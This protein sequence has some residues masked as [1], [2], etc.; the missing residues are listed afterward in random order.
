MSRKYWVYK[1]SRIL[2]PFDKDAFAGLPGVD[3]TTLVSAGD[4]A[5]SGEGGWLP[6]GEIAELTG[7]ALDIG[8][9]W[10]HDELSVTYGLLDKLQIEAAGLIDDDDFPGAA[11]D[12]FQDA[13]QKKNFADLL[14]PR[15]A[16]AEAE[17]RRSKDRVSELTVQLEMLYKR[18]SE[19]ESS[20]TD[21]MHRLAE[22]EVALRLPPPMPVAA[23]PAAAPPAV[24]PPAAAPP[25][26]VAPVAAAPAAAPPAAVSPSLP[27]TPTPIQEPPVAEAPP[28]PEMPALA[29]A[30]APALELIP[31]PALPPLPE[32]TPPPAAVPPKKTSYPKPLHFK[33]VPTIR[34]FRIVSED[35]L[36]EPKPSAAEDAAPA[37]V[38]AKLPTLAPIVVPLPEPVLPQS[39]VPVPVPAPVEAPV[40]PPEIEVV[41]PPSV[42]VP[43]PVGAPAFAPVIEV[44]SM[45]R[46]QEPAPAA[47][48][49]AE[50]AAGAAFEDLARAPGEITAPVPAPPPVQEPAAAPPVTMSFAWGGEP[51][52]SSA[53]PPSTQEVLARLSKPGPAPQTTKPR[54]VRSNKPALFAG[55]ALVALLAVIG[56]FLLRQ[57][58]DLKQM[59]SLDDN[60]EHLGA[61]PVDEA[62]RIPLPKPE[63]AE[64]PAPDVPAQ[65]VPAGP[66]AEASGSQ[67]AAQA[68]LDAAVALA[69]DFP[70]DGGR[71]TVAQWLQYSYNASPDAGS[72]TWSASSTGDKGYLVEYRFVPTARGGADVHYLFAADMSLGL[73]Y[74]K[75]LEAQRMLAG[76]APR[77]TDQKPK[78]RAK[79]KAKTSRPAAKRPARRAAAAEIPREVPLMPLPDEGELKPPA[80]DDSAFGADTVNSGL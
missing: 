13:D 26:A 24:A 76:S 36:G 42:P 63:V 29:A 68:E 52:A 21:L 41:A 39:S 51:E 12:L 80:E 40:S 32:P 65:P 67:P 27:P 22:K 25:V 8:V 62:A 45:P 14:N 53:P 5:A 46:T 7:V 50:P 78:P 4:S 74:G 28:L 64:T 43:A 3:S 1:D 61:Q 35:I 56:Y 49:P 77:L 79:P 23:P 2:G 33:V 58:K 17:L 48:A 59:V 55:V 11:E 44:V 72:E 37:S 47:A 73:I 71:G 20:Q 34:S 75:N 60:R 18:V 10:P 16:A 30:P 66:P 15:P 69:K 6:A 38:P 57:P 70:L 31:P 54:Q 19:L 9:S